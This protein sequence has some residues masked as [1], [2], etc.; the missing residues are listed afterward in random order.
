MYIIV[1]DTGDHE[2]HL[3]VEEPLLI[4]SASKE[5]GQNMYWE[6][7]NFGSCFISEP[8]GRNRKKKRKPRF[9]V[10]KQETVTLFLIMVKICF[11]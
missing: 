4:K 8:K 7:E 10:K 11:C 1:L 6:I 9:L 5:L 3:F 2:L